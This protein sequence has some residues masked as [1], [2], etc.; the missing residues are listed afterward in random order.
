[1]LERVSTYSFVL[2]LHIMAVL[3]AY[4]LP[5]AYPLLLPYVR[6]HHPEALA[7]VHAVQ[8]RLNVVLTGPGT[9]LILAF[10]IYLATKGHHWGEIWV[11]VP[12]IIIALIAVLGGGVIVPATRRLAELAGAGGEAYERVYR[13]YMAVEILLGVLVLTA[14]FMMAAKP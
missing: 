6:R 3:A 4:G 5:L 2:A 7:G 13:R 11:T 12:V 1:M 14:V 9:V 8:Y 10:G